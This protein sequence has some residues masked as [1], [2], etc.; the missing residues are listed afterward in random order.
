MNPPHDFLQKESLPIR[1]DFVRREGLF[2]QGL[3]EPG[4]GPRLFEHHLLEGFNER[5]QFT[6][7]G[8]AAHVDNER[9]GEGRTEVLHDVVDGQLQRLGLVEE[10]DEGCLY[11]RI[12]VRNT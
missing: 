11:S 2:E 5:V 1:V 7:S 6:A 4:L 9:L 12:S 3:L 10:D 8:I